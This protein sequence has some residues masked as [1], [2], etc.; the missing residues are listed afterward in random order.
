[1]AKP[2]DSVSKPPRRGRPPGSVR[3]TERHLRVS[4]WLSESAYDDLGVYAK[5]TYGEPINMSRTV[6]G[7]VLEKLGRL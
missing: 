4:F 5:K 7:I 2:V 1:M 3:Q 6:R